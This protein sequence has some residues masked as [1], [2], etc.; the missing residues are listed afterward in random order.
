MTTIFDESET[1]PDNISDAYKGILRS[2]HSDETPILIYWNSH[3]ALE[4][5]WGMFTKYWNNFFYY[6]EDA[7]IYV[8]QVEVYFYNEMMLKKINKL[9]S[10]SGESIFD[11]LQKLKESNK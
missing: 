4:T 6:P 5:T 1:D 8:N 9:K 11:C 10:V 7:I 3:V 2:L